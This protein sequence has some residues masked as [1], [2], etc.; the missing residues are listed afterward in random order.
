MLELNQ[1][2]LQ[3][4]EEPG[5]CIVVA[6]PGCGKTATLVA[7]AVRIMEMQTGKK[8]LML[9][10]TQK[11][12]KEMKE[13]V[14]KSLGNGKYE[15]KSLFVGTIHSWAYKFLKSKGIKVEVV[16]EKQQRVWVLEGARELGWKQASWR[17]L[18]LQISL[19]KQMLAIGES[20]KAS[21]A[22]DGKLAKLVLKY[23]QK[24]RENN[25]VDF[26]DILI[27]CREVL[28]QGDELKI[29]DDFVYDH[30]L[31]DEFQDLDLVQFDIVRHLQRLNRAVVFTV[32]DSKQG[33]YGFRGARNDLTNK[34]SDCLEPKPVRIVLEKTYRCPQAII[35]LASSL[36]GD[37][38]KLQSYASKHG[39]VFHIF[40]DSDYTEAAWMANTIKSL[41]G[42]TDSATVSNYISNAISLGDFAVL[43][44]S[45]H[46][47]G[48]IAKEFDSSTLPYQ[49]MSDKH[50]SGIARLEKIYNFLSRLN[51]QMGNPDNFNL[52][53]NEADFSTAIFGLSDD[54][55]L[56]ELW[57]QVKLAGKLETNQKT[58]TWQLQI[59]A[60]AYE[61]LNV[62]YK[63]A[64]P[65]FLERWQLLQI[66]DQMIESEKISLMSIHAAKGLEF[67]VVFVV[68]FDEGLLPRVSE[69]D[70]EGDEFDREEERR[71][72]YVA[73][74]RA[75]ESVF[76]TSAKRRERYGKRVEM[77]P[78]SFVEEMKSELIT[79]VT[80]DEFL[81]SYAK[82]RA[83]ARV[84]KQQMKMF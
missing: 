40:T 67:K 22:E 50:W 28:I 6:G 71:L 54:L 2:Q 73:L 84:K 26:D 44:R 25:L 13:R 78:S 1:Q 29:A 72:L 51:R 11:A 79:Q 46:T 62:P 10:F 45:Y 47:T 70:K 66:H 57:K 68:G 27:R 82:R 74:T 33:I 5:H 41:S 17:K 55:S 61:Y 52:S 56:V 49:L 80:H 31:L 3:A 64:L 59:D 34:L 4:I 39:Q 81:D 76:L 58:K 16:S 35:D 69:N 65:E 14:E 19:L 36:F 20:D 53:K 15:R 23:E 18:L 21:K 75:K 32:G 9:T 8:V 77:Q 42:M 37:N 63:Q 43:S 48:L 38:E 7:R 12:A 24:L 60:L 30:I 83:K